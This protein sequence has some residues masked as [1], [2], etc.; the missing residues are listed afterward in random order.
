MTTQGIS[1]GVSRNDPNYDDDFPTGPGT[2]EITPTGEELAQAHAAALEQSKKNERDSTETAD[3][4]P[5]DQKPAES[6]EPSPSRIT[7]D[8]K[9]PFWMSIYVTENRKYIEYF[10]GA[11][12]ETDAKTHAEDKAT[13]SGHPCAV[14]GPQSAVYAVPEQIV[15]KPLD[16]DWMSD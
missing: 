9:K 12:A 6:R 16:L 7:L 10:Q 4:K 8:L 1:G 11:D 3:E 14:F 13:K 5:G 2:G 15:A